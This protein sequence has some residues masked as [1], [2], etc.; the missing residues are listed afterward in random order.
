MDRTL[1]APFLHSSFLQ[2][3]YVRTCSDNHVCF[4]NEVE[5]TNRTCFLTQ[6]QY[7]NTRNWH[8]RLAPHAS[9]QNLTHVD[10]RLLHPSRSKSFKAARLGVVKMTHSFIPAEIMRHKETSSILSGKISSGHASVGRYLTLASSSYF[11]GVVNVEDSC[12]GGS[13]DRS[14]KIST[15]TRSR[16]R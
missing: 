3:I 12:Y 11:T 1:T 8:K 2:A 9:E 10:G 16:R 6:S 15:I 13:R 14:L 4:N 7:I 5:V